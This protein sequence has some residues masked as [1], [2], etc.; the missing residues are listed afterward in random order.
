MLIYRYFI[1]VD[2]IWDK[3]SWEAIKHALEGNSCGS[4]VI[5]TTRNL[6]VVTKA[7]EVHR[8]KPL[9][10][11]NSKKL[12]YK[13]IQSEEGEIIYDPLDEV[14]SKI[15]Y[16]CDGVPLA[17]ISM[18]SLLVDRPWEDWK[19]VYESIGFGNGDNTMKILSYSYNDLPSYLKPC[20]LHLSIYPEDFVFDTNSMIWVWIGEGFVQYYE[21]GDN[22]FEVGERYFKELVNRSMIQPMEDKFDQFAQWFR[23]HDIVFDLICELARDENYATILG[24]R[25]QQ[26]SPASSREKKIS[27]PRLEKVRRLVV[28]N[29]QAQNLPGETMDKPEV[30]RSLHII[31]SEI[32]TMA[33]LD[34]FRICRVLYIHGSNVPIHFKHMGRLLHLKYLEIQ[35]T[36]VAE[37]PKEIGHLKSLQALLLIN[38]GLQELPPAVCSLTQLMCLIVEGFE[39]FPADR[40]GNLTSLEELRLKSVAGRSSTEDLVVELGKLTRLRM[41]TITFSEQLEESLQKALVQSLCNMRDLQELALFSKKMPSQ[42]GDS[43]WEGWV[44][45]RKLRRLLISGIIFTRRPEWINNYHLPLLYF[46]CVDVYVV[47]V[48]DLDNLARLQKLSYLMM[49]DSFIWPPAYTVRTDSFK[50]IKFCFVGTALKFHVGAMPRL[51]QLQFGVNAGHGTWEVHGVP[52]EQIRTKDAIADLEL[53]LDNLLSLEIVAPNINCLGASAAEVEEVEAVVRGQL[54]GHP[55][56]PTVIVNRVNEKY[57][58]PDEHLEAQV[59]HYL[60]L[61]LRCINYY[62]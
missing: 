14:S 4:K 49:L 21:K 3:D 29:H 54:E 60:C 42:P 11:D 9:S 24:S 44:P 1:V 47:Q 62:C 34:S 41:V 61:F 18:A 19:K 10:Y 26:A 45:P 43:A 53:G 16:K 8:L 27:M 7:E 6:E 13:R 30:L 17:I 25:E 57:M 38:I 40:M 15:I 52:F 20:L 5:M 32:G 55:N 22:P 12:F 37:L 58:L 35:E 33:P 46:L 48:Q 36:P 2:D 59:R 50:N 56:R 51:E 31:G 23:V 39:R 28:L